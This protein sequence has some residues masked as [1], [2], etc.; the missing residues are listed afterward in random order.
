MAH[1]VCPLHVFK[2][3]DMKN[4][5]DKHDSSTISLALSISVLYAAGPKDSPCTPLVFDMPFEFSGLLFAI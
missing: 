5:M 1:I 4:L 2:S 3:L